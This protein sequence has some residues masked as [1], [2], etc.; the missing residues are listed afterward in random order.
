M[1][2][3]VAFASSKMRPNSVGAHKKLGLATPESKYQVVKMYRSCGGF[4]EQYST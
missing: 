3:E 2:L 1:I 4:G